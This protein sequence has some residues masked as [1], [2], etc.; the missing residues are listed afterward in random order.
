MHIKRSAVKADRNRF[1]DQ[2]SKDVT[3]A[4]VSR[5]KQ[6]FQRVRRAFPKAASAKRSGFVALPAVELEDGTLAATCADRAQR[7]RDH[8]MGQE[9]GR[10]VSAKEY[11][12]EL[13]QKDRQCQD[14]PVLSDSSVLPSLAAL[15]TAV[16]SLRR[17]KAAGPDG[18]TSELLRV[19]PT[20]SARRL[21]ALYLK[22]TLALREPIE[23]KG[24]A[25]MTLAKRAAMSFGCDK[26]RSIMLSSV[27]GK[28]FHKA[29]RDKITPHLFRM[30][31]D[32]HGG[33]RAG[34]GVDTISLSVKCFQAL[35]AAAGELP[36][37][38]FYD[39]RAAYYQVLRECLTGDEPDD[40][41]L[42]RFFHKLGVPA[43]A[44][45][46]LR[47][48]LEGMSIL[49]ENGCEPHLVAILREVFA[50]TWFRLDCHAPLVATS[51]GVRPGDPLADVLFAV[52][53]SA[54]TR[55][56]QCALR[57]A[58][59]ETLLPPCARQ[60]PWD[61][62]NGPVELGPASWADDF[63]ALHAAATPGGLV[64]RV[65]SATG[66]FLTH[67]TSNGI[68]L[69]FAVDKTAV[70]LPPRVAFCADVG[71]QNGPT[72][73]YLA[74]QDAITGTRQSMPVVQAYKHLGGIITNTA[75]VAP[76]VHYRFSQ[77]TWT[78]RPLRGILFGNPSIPLPTR[79]HLLQSLVESKFTFG[80]ATLELH[81]VG[82]VRLW[83]RLYVSLFR[84]LQPRSAA[85]RKCHSYAVLQT[86]RVCTPPLA[87]AKARGSFLLRVL[88]QGPA[89]LRHLLLLQWEASPTHSWLGQLH[90]DPVRALLEVMIDD[91]TWWKRQVQAAIRICLSDVDRWVQGVPPAGASAAPTASAPTELMDFPC[92]FCSAQFPLR[93]HLGAHMAR[94][95]GMV[96]P[97]RLYMP[98]PTCV[99]CLRHYHTLPRVQRHLRGSKACLL[100]ASLLMPPM[101]IAEVKEVEAADVTRAKKLRRGSW[102]LYTAAL[103]VLPVYGPSQPT[104]AELR[105]HLDDEAPLSLLADPPVDPGFLAWIQAEAGFTTREPQRGSSAS[106]WQQRIPVGCGN[107]RA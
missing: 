67:A 78:L 56:V 45:G 76:E 81:T 107:V 89:T 84:S 68:Q 62:P 21:F 61:T 92:P 10:S 101:S 66:V 100:R 95:H 106:F 55:A 86:A 70:V 49:A 97:A 15:E 9:S 80:S 59:L 64:Q 29:L 25:L 41:V 16:L 105:A 22:S 83:S 8:F 17:A 69:A 88:E 5:P 103:P 19:A 11:Q 32:L 26:H 31:P 73:P 27:P 36:A 96:A 93:K 53:F 30:C 7:W 52:S 42:L 44:I 18:I 54:Y 58:G 90:D 38:V 102:Q 98:Q 3:L 43:E 104:R 23:F 51:A 33:V 71:I 65:V 14:R 75:T 46:E 91:R 4:D 37:V 40:R 34:I 6:L 50:G 85:Q 35:A 24:G 1:L 20:D 47:S 74:I 99:V 94:R 60:P 79:R 48:K 12:L 63:A 13:L 39:V 57:A 28:L 72:G 87:L 77:A 2:L 82:S